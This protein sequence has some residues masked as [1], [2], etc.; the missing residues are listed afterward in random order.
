MNPRQ[1]RS[2]TKRSPRLTSAGSESGSN[3]RRGRPRIF[4]RARSAAHDP[5]RL[6]PSHPRARH[7]AMLLARDRTQQPTPTRPIQELAMQMLNL[8]DSVRLFVLFDAFAQSGAD[9]S[10][11]V[12]HDRDDDSI[13]ETLVQWARMRNQQLTTT[14]MIGDGMRWSLHEV[15]VGSVRIVVHGRS[16]GWASGE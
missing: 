7:V 12:L 1:P 16:F 13:S 6:L 4:G 8:H 15:K 10:E 14:G 5:P 9:N 11:I 2:P 3:P